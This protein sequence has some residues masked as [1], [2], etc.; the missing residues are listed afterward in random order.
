MSM[1]NEHQRARLLLYL[2]AAA[3]LG[4][5]WL[6]SGW[7][8]LPEH[9]GFGGSLLHESSP[10]AALVQAAVIAAIGGA[11]G[12][13]LMGRVHFEATILGAA[14]ALLAISLRGGPVRYALFDGTTPSVLI[15][16]AFETLLLFAILYA[17]FVASEM[18]RRRRLLRESLD[19]LVPDDA[20][21]VDQRLLGTVTHAATMAVLLFFLC[22]TQ[23][24]PQVIA[25][26]FASGMLAT[27]AAHQFV[28]MRPGAWFWMSP[29]LVGMLGYVSSYF[30]TP[31]IDLGEPG[32]YLAPLARPLPIDYATAGV[33]GS[34]IGYWISRRWHAAKLAEEAAADAAPPPAATF[35]N[36]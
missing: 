12:A 22:A 21:P 13:V 1:L 16:L 24:K 36:G 29:L 15:R 9:Q 26:V 17:V 14:F 32:G 5:G 28:P 25:T 4:F 7:F 34:L 2:T 33:A 35:P 6:L 18:L 19:T 20:E 27:M 30:G 3:A 8:G 31:S 11:I 23:D 10:L